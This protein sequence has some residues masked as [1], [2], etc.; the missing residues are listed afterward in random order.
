M[1]PLF[2]ILGQGFLVTLQLALT[3]GFLGLMFGMV[4]AVA[5][6]R[7]R[8]RG[9]AGKMIQFCV[10]I[11]RGLPLLVIVMAVYFCGPAVGMDVSP[12]GAASSCL[13]LYGAVYFGIAMAA[14]HAAV[15]QTQKQA[16]L[17]TGLSAFQIEIFIVLPQALRIAIPMLLAQLAV[18]IKE[19]AVVSVVGI[20]DLNRAG[21]LI[22]QRNQEVM[23]T[24][25]V[26]AVGYFAVCFGLVSLSRVS[27]FSR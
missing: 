15:P 6:V 12:M 8:D 14:A 24:F 27:R 7:F 16:G 23:L 26:V 1:K 9:V 2:E 10:D 11:V 22:A 13:T 25:G 21:W 18:L 3:S 5:L 19:S 4:V 20:T 17:A